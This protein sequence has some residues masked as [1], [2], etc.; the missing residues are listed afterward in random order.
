M[1][2]IFPQA[3]A[4]ESA[5]GALVLSFTGELDLDAQATTSVAFLLPDST[6]GTVT[7][8]LGAVTFI[9]SAGI[10]L[11]LNAVRRAHDLGL[12]V[13]TVNVRTNVNRTLTSLD[14]TSVLGVTG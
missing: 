7:F 6:T 14:L 1:M 3:I 4:R 8:D 13:E 10:G 2:T 9:D 5:R 11:L 12:V